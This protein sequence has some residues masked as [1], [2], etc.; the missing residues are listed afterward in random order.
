M[1]RI[2]RARPVVHRATGLL[3]LVGLV[4]GAA[5][6]GGPGEI[7]P[8]T[9]QQV[10]Q[11]GDSAALALMQ[12]LSGE[13]TRA[14]AAGGPAHAIA[15]CAED[16][17]PLTASVVAGLGPGWDVKRTTL[18]TR[19]P[20]NE[21]DALELDALAFFHGAE[22]A[23]RELPQHY[24]QRTPSGDYRYY[25]PLMVAPL[26]VECHGPRAELDPAVTRVLAERYPDDYATGY[27]VGDLRGVVR[28]TVP[29]GALR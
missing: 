21:P 14:M 25:R 10:I 17:G 12:S 7:D 24:V 15:F 9:R 2:Y 27:R 3:T 5:A 26:C 6:C 1:R 20:A 8:D 29:R 11:V 4:T 19:N 13:L 18:Q 23:G 22:T 28:V 16:A